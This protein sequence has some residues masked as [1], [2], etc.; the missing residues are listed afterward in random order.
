MMETKR[1]EMRYFENLT[2]DGDN[3]YVFNKVIIT[4]SIMYN[5]FNCCCYTLLFCQPKVNHHTTST[6]H[7]NFNFIL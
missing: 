1:D 2:L 3:T 6:H 4:S 5:F 7:R